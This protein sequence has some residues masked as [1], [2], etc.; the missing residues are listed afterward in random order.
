MNKKIFLIFTT[1]LLTACA[2]TSYNAPFV[3]VE[4]TIELSTGLSRADIITIM[5]KPLYSEFGDSEIDQIFWVYDVRNKNVKSSLDISGQIIPNK[6]HK[7]H[8]PSDPIHKLRLEFRNNKLYRWYPIEASMDVNNKSVELPRKKSK[9]TFF[10]QPQ[11]ALYYIKEWDCYRC[12]NTSALYYGGFFGARFESGEKIGVSITGEFPTESEGKEVYIEDSDYYSGGYTDYRYERSSGLSV[13]VQY[14]R[15]N[16]TAQ[17][18]ILTM[19]LGFAVH[20]WRD[21]DGSNGFT[22]GFGKVSIGR[23]L[24]IGSRRIIP[25]LDIILGVGSYIGISLGLEL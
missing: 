2:T 15:P 6:T 3:D 20:D 16:F 17:Q 12:D 9:K 8:R 23:K 4:E 24:N 7:T 22:I 1:L 5:G 11:L 10:F 13:M 21:Y 19:G 25:Q 14:E 18:L